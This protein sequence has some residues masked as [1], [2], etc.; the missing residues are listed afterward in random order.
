MPNDSIVP[1][2]KNTV[3]S[4]VWTNKN[5]YVFKD[6]IGF[7]RVS[8]N[9]ETN[10]ITFASFLYEILQFSFEKTKFINWLKMDTLFFFEKTKNRIEKWFHLKRCAMTSSTQ[11]KIN[12][13]FYDLM[14]FTDLDNTFTR[15][16]ALGWLFDPALQFCILVI[17]FRLQ[18]RT[19][20]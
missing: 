17:N 7:T 9:C 10:F 18:K 12:Y 4:F 5:F 14:F 2:P 3:G 1:I 6:I 11:K 13:H 19:S 20:K 15:S 8:F 16:L